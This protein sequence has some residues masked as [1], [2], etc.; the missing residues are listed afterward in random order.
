MSAITTGS[1]NETARSAVRRAFTLIELFVVNSHLFKERGDK[2]HNG[3][4]IPCL[5]GSAS[6]MFLRPPFPQS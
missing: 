1:G 3:L 4:T 2:R 6:I 5:N